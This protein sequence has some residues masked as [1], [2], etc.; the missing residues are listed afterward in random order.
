AASV[1]SE[2]GSNSRLKPVAWAKNKN[3]FDFSKASLPKQ[4]V[5]SL[6]STQSHSGSP[7][8]FRTDS[9]TS[10]QLS[11]SKAPLS[12]RKATNNLVSIGTGFRN[13]NTSLLGVLRFPQT[14]TAPTEGPELGKSDEKK[15]GS[16]PHSPPWVSGLGRS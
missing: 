12:S 14:S 6:D 5:D 10:Y 2:P 7:N 9:G 8:G 3:A 11:K 13:V 15:A 1:R 4:I 16:R